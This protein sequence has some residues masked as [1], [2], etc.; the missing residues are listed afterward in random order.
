[1]HHCSSSYGRLHQMSAGAPLCEE[2]E[3]FLSH[4]HQMGASYRELRL[5]AGYL[6][7]IIRI[8]DLASLRAVS[9]QEIQAAGD[10]WARYSGPER[11]SV[12][13]PGSPRYLVRF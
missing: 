1:M 8:L 5:V 6:L 10:R 12:H 2:R 9:E 11:H 4:L 13:R 7:H 3:A